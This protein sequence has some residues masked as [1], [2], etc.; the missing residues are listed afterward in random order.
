VFS[1]EEVLSLIVVRGQLLQ[2][3]EPGR[4]LAVSCGEAQLRDLLEESA[5]SLAAVNGPMQCVVSGASS[6]IEILQG[7]LETAEISSRVL[8]TSHAFHSAMVEPILDTYEQC[9]AEVKRNR[10][11]IPFIS[12]VSGT[13]ITEEQATSPS[14]WA[15]HMR[16]TVRFGDG[17]QELLEL[18]SCIML[19]VGPGHSL[20]TLVNRR[21]GASLERAVPTLGYDRSLPGERQAVL[22][23][24][25]RLWLHGIDIDWARLHKDTQPKRVPLPSYAFDRKRFWIERGPGL[26]RMAAAAAANTGGETW[27][28]ATAKDEPLEGLA[29]YARPELQTTYVAPGNEIEAK[30]VEIWQSYLGIENIGVRDNFFELGGDSLL[31]TR[32]YA[33]IKKELEVELPAGKMFEFA[34]IR[35][36]Y[37]F[38][39]TSNNQTAID[40]LSEEELDEF[41]ALMES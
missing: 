9:V 39:A 33:Q 4:M 17:A 23:A 35:H 25:G 5:C 11:A 10:P 36:M 3:L 31:A 24:I 16:E 20:S 22:N 8:R 29:A 19:E 18:G 21:A 37:L 1:L 38:I 32:V 28:E 40:A 6:D 14:Y 30:L 41:L 27:T 13:W 34:T 2:S 15:R 7:R 26:G 12:N